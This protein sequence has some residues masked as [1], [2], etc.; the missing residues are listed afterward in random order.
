MAI[1]IKNNFKTDGIYP[2]D[3]GGRNLITKAKDYSRGCFEK[4]YDHFYFFSY[5]NVSDFTCAYYD[6]TDSIEYLQVNQYSLLK[7]SES[8]LEFLDEIEIKEMKFIG[9]YKYVYYSIYNP[10]STKMYHGIIDITKNLVV[11]NTDE[12]I[13]T[14]TPYSEYSMLAITQT[15]AYE[16]CVIKKDGVCIDSHSC[17]GNNNNYILDKDGNKCSDVCDDG[18]F[19]LI[20]QN[21]CIDSCD[22]SIYIIN[23][24]RCGLCR[25][26][27][28][29]RPYRLIDVSNCFSE[30][31]IPENTEI[32]D[33]KFYLLKCKNGY[34]FENGKCI[35][36]CYE[37]C[38]TCSEYSD[39]I[40]SQKCLTCKP[41][42]IIDNNNNCIF[43]PATIP[44]SMPKIILNTTITNIQTTIP[45]Q[46]T[47]TTIITKIP[48][49]IPTHSYKNESIIENTS[50]SEDKIC[51]IE[52][53]INDTCREGKMN[54]S[55]INNI[56][57]YLKNKMNEGI[58]ESMRTLKTDNVIIQFGT[59]DEQKDSSDKDVSNIDLG[60]CENK[61]KTEYNISDNISLIVYKVDIKNSDLSATYVQ[62]EIYHPITK[63]QL[64]MS[65]CNEMKIT[66]DTPVDIGNQM[67]ELYNS[68]SDSGYN[69]FNSNDSFYQ[70]ICTTYTTINGNDML[71]SDR[72]KDIYSLSADISMSQTG[73]TLESYNSETKKLNVIAISKIHL[74]QLKI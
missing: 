50:I 62:Y 15:N 6:L 18:K 33:S 9:N 11:F 3:C 25:D 8:P 49:S 55:D 12:E 54:L 39:D 47:K 37:N 53:I 24:T 27:Y 70:D 41:D 35:Q 56:K 29:D 30:S 5:T 4:N 73:C 42:F 46:I 34:K 59:L 7:H 22:E 69:L 40:N 52:E 68:L 28:P 60:E 57:N 32:Y 13:L 44:I 16:V 63:I 17:I 26:Y 64:N 71:L 48:T 66:I 20:K 38:Q 51:S 2:N 10:T 72:K 43:S 19:L 65:L 31:E 61:L 74:H 14:F 67:E 23:G 1:R 58:D 36:N 45:K 21:F